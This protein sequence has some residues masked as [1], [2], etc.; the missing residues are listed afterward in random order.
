MCAAR[1]RHV[2]AAAADA[3]FGSR[4]RSVIL[5]PL[6]EPAAAITQTKPASFRRLH[7]M[8]EMEDPRSA[9][10]GAE[11]GCLA[12]VKRSILHT[13]RCDFTLFFDCQIF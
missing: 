8:P 7:V 5:L 2:P 11:S 10:S 4:R 12:S 9:A 1:F 3:P 6:P 13:A